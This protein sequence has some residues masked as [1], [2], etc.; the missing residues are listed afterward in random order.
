MKSPK[1]GRRRRGRR[2]DCVDMC[3]YASARRVS[4]Y[5]AGVAH[6]CVTPTGHATGAVVVVVV[7]Q[8]PPRAESTGGCRWVLILSV[9]RRLLAA[10]SAALAAVHISI[11]RRQ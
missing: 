7:V 1:E 3:V 8:V 6:A 10:E 11:H 4:P 9:I 2:G 5:S